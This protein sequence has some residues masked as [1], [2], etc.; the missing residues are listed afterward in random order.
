MTAAASPDSL[1]ALYKDLHAHPE[2]GFVELRTAS[3]VAER[4]SVLGLDVTEHVGGT[5]VVAVLANGHGRTVW[6]RADMDGL[7]VLEQTGLDYAS[8]AVG[9]GV[10]AGV[11]LMHACGH[12]MHVTWLVGAMERL[13]AERESWSGTVVAIF[14]PA[15]ELI[16]GAQ[17]MLDGGLVERFPKPDVVLGQ[18]VGPL[19]AGVVSLTAGAAMAGADEL[20]IVLHGKGGH[21]SR[22][23]AT[24]DPILAAS[25]TVVAL[26][27]IVSREV[28]PGQLVVVTVGQLHAGTKNNIIPDQARLGLNIRTISA[29]T[30]ERVLASIHRIVAAEADAA[31]MTEPPSIEHAG[32]APATLNSPP[33]VAA[34]RAAFGGAWGESQ[35]IDYGTVAGSED[36]SLLATASGAPLVFWITGGA[37]P[38]QFAAAIAAD[39]FEQYIPSNHSPFFAPVLEPTVG[40][41]VDAL[42]VAAQTFLAEPG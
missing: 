28:T 24:I 26:Q 13:V 39:R 21:G 38:A 22:P 9:T 7:P 20:D 4:M 2:L 25:A 1:V 19:P 31:G 29:P 32:S 35:V 40:H 16:A 33:H 27:S 17:A 23:E 3:I 37:D 6:L 36:V 5:G 42:V 34:L 12:D 18:H 15:E 41:G 14:Q 8:V 11:P 30:R 10:D